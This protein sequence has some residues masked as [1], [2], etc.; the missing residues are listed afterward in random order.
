MEQ[1]HFCAA[2]YWRTPLHPNT[3]PVYFG[4]WFASPTAGYRV[5]FPL[6]FPIVLSQFIDSLE[7]ARKN[8]DANTLRPE[9]LAIAW[10]G[11]QPYPCPS[12]PRAVL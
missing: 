11:R 2:V 6:S 12:V 9:G 10:A 8:M 1:P 7:Y 4:N 3:L 5:D